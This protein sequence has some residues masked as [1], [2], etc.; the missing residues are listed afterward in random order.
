[1]MRTRLLA[2]GLVVSFTA[3]SEDTPT[4]IV[5][6]IHAEAAVL[7]E[8]TNLTLTVS[9]AAASDSTFR[10]VAQ[11]PF[12]VNDALSLPLHAPIRPQDGDATRRLLV[13]VS[14]TNDMGDEIAHARAITGYVPG[15]SRALVLWLTARCLN[16][17][18][19]EGQTCSDGSC[20]DAMVDPGQLP[21]FGGHDAGPSSSDSGVMDGEVMD[22][23]ITD[24][25]SADT[26]PTPD[27]GMPDAG[28]DAGPPSCDVD[29]GGCD[30]LTACT[31]VEGTVEC[32]ACPDGYTGDGAIGCTDIDECETDN[33]GCGDPRYA[34]CI[35]N[36]GAVA[37]CSDIDAC[38]VDNGDCGDVAD[39][40]CRDNELVA[41]T[42]VARAVQISAGH[43]YNCVL[44]SD[45]RIY[46]WGFN[47]FG[48]VSGASADPNS[49]YVEVAAGAFHACGRTTMGTLRCWGQ[50]ADGQ[51]GRPS[52]DSAGDIVQVVAGSYHT[53]VRRESGQIQCWGRD[54]FGQ[55]SGP[56]GSSDNFIQI[57]A[58]AA[59]G[60]NLTCGVRTDNTVVCWGDNAHEQVSGPT[61]ATD[62][63]QV[64]TGQRHTCVRRLTGAI[65]CWGFD[66]SRVVSG[67]NMDSATDYDDI[68]VGRENTCARHTDGTMR[69]WGSD[70]VA[71]GGLID[72][73]A[74]RFSACAILPDGRPAC[75]IGDSDGQLIGMMADDPAEY[76]HVSVGNRKA[77]AL[78]ADGT[79]DCSS[80]PGPDDDVLGVYQ[81][82]EVSHFHGCALRDTGRIACWGDNRHGAVNGPNDD[83]RMDITQIAVG[84]DAGSSLTC[85]LRED[86]SISC[87]GSDH[88]GQVTGP[89]GSMT[90][91]Y[92][93]VAAGSEHSC[94][95]HDNGTVTCWGQDHGSAVS[96]PNGD[97]AGD[98][99]RLTAGHQHTCVTR[100]S[101]A[102]TCW[103]RN[104]GSVLT[105][106]QTISDYEQLSLGQNHACGIR[107]GN[108]LSCHGANGF[109]MGRAPE[110]D[111]GDAYVHAAAD[112]ATSCAVREDG[113]YLC[114]GIIYWDS[115]GLVVLDRP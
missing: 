23:G 17:Q 68:S 36:A 96:G 18:C 53:C 54:D 28:A 16:V 60:G 14:A 22:G 106:I 108:L 55:V 2:L 113:S 74:G 3:C 102:T 73:A 80:F 115:R 79:S 67:P 59:A 99:V 72:I 43:S 37:A 52:A 90:G 110:L 83:G 109:G 65:D 24:G 104:D 84:G 95:L 31:M 12:P 63:A 27:G 77:C 85:A 33:G 41:P 88:G 56:N 58:G 111:V 114:W 64:A 107:T 97:R 4:Q 29:N 101:G 105:G 38:M 82:L 44:R 5:A 45:G 47:Q 62:V 21:D 19:D 94:G 61:G 70:A 1:M 8:A 40:R 30:P 15:A 75:A 7:A 93:S 49:D 81:Q 91:D 71:G 78:R 98:I 39:F 42:C 86:R 92:L 89:N 26:M 13:E 25:G 87:W 51:A 69:C 35:N 103:G 9:G 20:V 48:A 11:F 10:Q 50:D 46:C 66:V 32:G 100:E 34:E 112:A 57:A 6:E 76:T